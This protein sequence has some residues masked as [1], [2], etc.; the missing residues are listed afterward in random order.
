M[1][2]ILDQQVI[3]EH[4]SIWTFAAAEIAR[5][6]R[7]GQFVI[8]RLDEN[9]ERLPFTLCDWDVEQG[10]ITLVIAERGRSTQEMRQRFRVGDVIRDL[11]GPLGRPSLIDHFGE[12]LLVGEGAAAGGLLPQ[13][14]A[15]RARG[16]GVRMLLGFD[17]ARD[18][19]WE[20][21]LRALSDEVTITTRDGERGL[22]IPLDE[23]LA[24]RLEIDRPDRVIVLGG[25]HTLRACA[26]RTRAFDLPTIVSLKTIM[27]DGAG[28][29]GSCRV[30]VGD[31]TR[32]ACLEGPEF[33]AH[34]ID[35]EELEQRQHRFASQEATASE[36][37]ERR[38][39]MK[40][41]LFEEDRHHIH[42][43]RE[44]AP[45]AYRPVERP[46]R[47]RLNDF[48]E[49]ESTYR[50][51]DALAEAQRCLQCA[52]PSCVSGC[53]AGVDIPGFI[54]HLLVCNV[55][56]ARDTIQE[57]H[58]F[59]AICGR[60]CPQES[61]C[62]AH[63]IVGRKVDPVAIGRLERFVGDTAPAR[64]SRVTEQPGRVAIVGAGP[65]GLACAEDLARRGF[66]V[67][68]FEALHAAGGLLRTGIP[69]FVMPPTILE[70]EIES[71]RALGAE[72]R[73][74]TVIG[75]TRTIPQL[76]QADGFDAVFVG[77][78]ASHPV[79]PGIPGENARQVYT[80]NELLTRVNLMGSDE[81]PFRGTPLVL[82]EAVVILG[83]GNTAIDCARVARRL[84]VPTVYC[85]YRRSRKEAPARPVELERAHDEGIQF[86]WL[87]SPDQILTTESGDVAGIR[88]LPMRLGEPDPRGRRRPLPSG[89]SPRTLTCSAV[90]LALGSRGHTL[91]HEAIPGLAIREPGRPIV[92]AATQATS[93]PGLFAGGD[94][95]T[96]PA[97]VV[98][99]LAAGRRAAAG[100]ADWLERRTWPPTAPES[101]VSS[102]NAS[103]EPTCERCGRPRLEDEEAWCC[104][105]TELGWRCLGC[106]KRSEGFAFPYGFCPS[107]GGELELLEAK[108]G[109]TEAGDAI[110]EALELGLGAVA[111]FEQ[112]ARETGDLT[113]R[114]L[115]ERLADRERR[116]VATL[117]RRYHVSA[118]EAAPISTER[119]ALHAGVAPPDGD[120]AALL[121]LAIRLEIEARDHF[122][123]RS[124]EHP[125]ASATAVLYRELA[126]EEQDHVHQ[127]ET[128]LARLREGQPGLW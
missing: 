101:A 97:T 82:G 103:P 33:D 23:A 120:A 69:S 72:I 21:R 124:T 84:G 7:A 62:E 95:A 112:A 121:E 32:F 117:E 99:A 4:L 37:L 47:E 52:R 38:C 3:S 88:L 113:V 98:R 126:A 100:I 77:A 96:G 42:K 79:L 25:N 73:L 114:M 26:E 85:V 102:R 122:R 10:T 91:W 115:L 30:R 8:L 36:E 39:R 53:P 5:A 106:G 81:F 35:F 22:A 65:A 6:A 27:V 83:G 76:L 15:L 2:R 18:V 109:L 60:V 49:V 67:T 43:I 51:A 44:V 29:C 17:R 105:D 110:R 74:N 46:V 59:P 28:Q 56:A 125:D 20:E 13:A 68:V 89:D 75:R 24:G 86:R 31:E 12:V 45:R 128:E 58:P 93:W 63:C 61:Q 48:A 64:R 14:R 40:T 108:T 9:G 1:F 111:F 70:R 78:G 50:W 119:V 55:D 123:H 57:A 92:D 34:A 71:L 94:A 41:M 87:E 16:N 19:F 11:S 54:R 90:I 107:C 116:H 118:V 127:L 66:D 80:A 104:G